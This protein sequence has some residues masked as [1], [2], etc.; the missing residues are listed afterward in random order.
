M[1]DTD[2]FTTGIL[3]AA[4]NGSRMNTDKLLIPFGDSTV[5]TSALQ[6]LLE[7][8]LISEVVVVVN[9]SFDLA[10]DDPKCTVVV[11]HGYQ[12]GMASSLRVGLMAATAGAEAYVIALG[13]MPRI[14]RAVV[15]HCVSMFQASEKRILV[16]TFNAQHGHPVVFDR[17]CKRDLMKLTGDVG[18]RRII[19]ENPDLVHFLPVDDD[20]VL[21][22]VDT[23]ADLAR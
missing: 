18:A 15:D 21:Y 17:K 19:K 13:D 6:P 4:G 10:L 12:E 14:N 23:P 16:P 8:K 7:S 9:P 22:D 11:N 2:M 1:D 3:L 5:F 20:G